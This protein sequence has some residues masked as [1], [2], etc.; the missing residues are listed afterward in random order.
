MIDQ[1]KF[2]YELANIISTEITLRARKRVM[3][4][5]EQSNK[6]FKKQPNTN[7]LSF[8]LSEAIAMRIVSAHMI[9]DFLLTIQPAVEDGGGKIDTYSKDLENILNE[10]AKIVMKDWVES[11]ERNDSLNGSREAFLRWKKLQGA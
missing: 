10:S 2:A 4:I 8:W 1:D 3:E 7:I 9:D 5:L 11:P 6:D